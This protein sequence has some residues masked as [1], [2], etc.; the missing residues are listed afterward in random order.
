M[1]HQ[2]TECARHQMARSKGSVYEG[3]VNVPFIVSSS[4][5]SEPA[6]ETDALV[7]FV[8]V[9]PTVAELA[10]VDLSALEVSYDGG[11]ALEID[12]LSFVDVLTDQDADPRALVYTEG[13]NP[14]VEAIVSG[15]GEWSGMISGSLSATALVLKPKSSLHW[16]LAPARRAMT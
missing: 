9:F 7:H 16:T 5:L 11:G 13:S 8:D 12:G 10:G 6:T 15:T 1:E 14:T 3:G 2:V 4:L